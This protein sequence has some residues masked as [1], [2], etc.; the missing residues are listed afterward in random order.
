MNHLNC[1]L[2]RQGISSRELWTQ[3]DQFTHNQIPISDRDAILCQNF[4]RNKN[5]SYSEKSK[6]SSYQTQNCE[7][8]EIHVGDIVYLYSDKTKHASRQ[9][10]I[11]VSVD[12][13]W[14]FI[15]KFTGNQLRSCSYKVKR[16]KCFRVPSD[17]KNVCDISHNIPNLAEFD[18]IV[19]RRY[20]KDLLF[21][22]TVHL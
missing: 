9:R 19:I 8:I 4:A 13:D 12:G 11:V 20:V 21:R 10:Y 6:C 22:T 14:C 7:T 5:Y 16:S 3:R 1:R 17:I 15:K 2:R 18:R